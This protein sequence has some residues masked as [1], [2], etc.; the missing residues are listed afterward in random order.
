MLKADEMMAV[1]N[2]SIEDYHLKDDV[3]TPEV[4]PFPIGSMQELLYSKNWIDTVQWHLE[5][6]IRNPNIE[7]VSALEI[8]RRIDASNQKRTDLVEQIDDA[9]LSLFKGV[10]LQSY[11][12]LNTE[13]PA[14]AID[15]FSILALKL[16]H[17]Q[18]EASRENNS[19]SLQAKNQMKLSVLQ[20]QEQ[21][22]T[23]AVDHLIEDLA[24]GR[25]ISKVYRQMKMYNDPELNPILYKNEE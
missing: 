6:I 15:R 23:T 17:M 11:A 16:Y 2:L 20:E 22:L 24:M 8:K 7:P 1:F 14:W 9:V 13:S 19:E 5:D 10:K 18:V 25:R 3:D 12:R 21:D 4:N